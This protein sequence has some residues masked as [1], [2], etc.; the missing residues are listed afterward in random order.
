MRHADALPGVHP[1][2]NI[3]G[4]PDVYEVENDAVDPDQLIEQAMWSIAPWEGQLVVDLGAGTGFHL[5]RF[6]ERAGGGWLR[7]RRPFRRDLSRQPAPTDVAKALRTA[8]LALTTGALVRILSL[9]CGSG[10]VVAQ[11]LPKQWVAGSNP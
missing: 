8:P 11:L 9:V 2:P 5:P 7:G 4:A 10:A 3:Q 1:A 6:H